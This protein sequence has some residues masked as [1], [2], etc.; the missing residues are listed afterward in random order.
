[1]WNFIKKVFGVLVA[2]YFS[3]SVFFC[4]TNIFIDEY[5][6][7][8]NQ[9]IRLFVNGR[10]VFHSPERGYAKP[11]LFQ[12]LNTEYIPPFSKLYWTMGSYRSDEFYLYPFAPFRRIIFSS[13]SDSI[14]GCICESFYLDYLSWKII[15]E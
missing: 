9:D 13:K 3:A 11:R 6:C 15:I 2:A 5:A 14:Y 7:D 1:M 8:V 10:E 12:K 4:Q